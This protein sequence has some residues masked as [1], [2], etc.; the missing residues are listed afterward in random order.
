MNLEV[1]EFPI[2]ELH[3][4]R[5]NP[6]RGDVDA[7]ASSLR[8]R[9]QYRP[10]VVN[11]GTNASK[12]MEI[13]AGNHTY[14]A[15]KQLGWKTIQATTVDVD[16]D[17][18][19][20]IVLADNRLADLGGYDEADLAVVLQSVSDL[21]GTGYSEDDLKTILASAGKP[22]ILNDPDDAPDVPDEGKTFTKEGQIWELGDSV[23]A[24]GSCTDDALVD[25][26]FGG[27]QADCVWTDPPYGV[28]YEGKTKD[29]LTIQ[30]D[31]G[32][33]FQE[34]VAD[35]FRQIVRC[36][37]PGTPAYVAHS[38]TARPFFQEA[39]EAAGC[40]F[41]ENLVWVK[42]TIVLGHS[43]Y[44]WKHEPILYG[45]T[46]GGTGRLGRGG[47][48]WYGDNKQATVFEFDKPSRNAEHPTMKPV[49][50]IE[51]MISNSCP[52]GGTVFDPFGGSGSTLIAAYDLKMRAVLCE[53]DPRYGDV[54]CRRFQEHTGIIPR[55]DGK[56]HDFTTE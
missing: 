21:E 34:V 39:F 47:D 20:Q 29:K 41:R 55:C 54:I 44:Q 7:I 16:D 33:D 45:F 24:V 28:A 30:N 15:A 17:Q 6:R 38:D 14:L 46:P 12:R 11:L 22:S 49:G 43:D 2:S 5:R 52:P 48:H 35:A 53:L 27:G 8:K 40:M 42:N 56:E 26:A 32:V 3:T 36:S 10:I 18:A 51:A 4:Y 25:K 50:L 19:A 37:K 13:L 23:L 1:R 9:G 31:S